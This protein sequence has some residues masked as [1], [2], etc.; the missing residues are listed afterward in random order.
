MSIKKWVK[1]MCFDLNFEK[2]VHLHPKI[3]HA[4]HKYVSDL[5]KTHEHFEKKWLA[6]LI[7]DFIDMLH[8][9]GEFNYDVDI[10][11]F[12]HGKQIEIKREL[13][14][15]QRMSQRLSERMPQRLTERMTDD[16]IIS[17]FNLS[18]QPL[19]I[20]YNTTLQ[21]AGNFI[22]KIKG[23]PK[24]FF[25]GIL[26]TGQNDSHILQIKGKKTEYYNLQGGIWP[27]SDLVNY[28][29]TMLHNKIDIFVTKESS[30]GIHEVVSIVIALRVLQKGG[31]LFMKIDPIFT[32]F[33]I[34]LLYMLSECFEH[35]NLHIDNGSM[36]VTGR[37]CKPLSVR[38]NVI[39][40]LMRIVE[41][42][43]FDMTADL[44]TTTVTEEK[45]VLF[46]YFAY[47]SLNS[48]NLQK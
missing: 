5:L 37:N 26:Q 3:K 19:S 41:E 35:F 33:K 9:K 28:I 27:E 8:L 10:N 30:W 17:M 46:Q 29:S 18:K 22:N 31:F 1:E 7:I 11:T 13:S 23:N 40:Q 32:I 48:S 25:N 47:A 44:L 39:D 14:L 34:K 16:K 21:N 24:W 4:I 20:F 2:L 45:Y 38:Q 15:I 36:F 43:H 6:E 12:N 42:R